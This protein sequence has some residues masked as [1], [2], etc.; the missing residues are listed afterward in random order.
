M[1]CILLEQEWKEE[2]QDSEALSQDLAP[3]S[4]LYQWLRASRG[5]NEKQAEH[6]ETDYGLHSAV[7]FICF[8]FKVLIEQMWNIFFS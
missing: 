2:R 6:E 4:S 8:G 3:S 5:L 1:I 7:Y